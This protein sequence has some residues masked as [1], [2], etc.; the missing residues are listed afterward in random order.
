MISPTAAAHRER[1]KAADNILL[2]VRQTKS[3]NRDAEI[4]VPTKISIKEVNERNAWYA[5][6]ASEMSDTLVYWDGNRHNE[7]S[8]NLGEQIYFCAFACLD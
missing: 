2:L 8:N 5:W 6:N 1:G 7:P 3:T 4:G